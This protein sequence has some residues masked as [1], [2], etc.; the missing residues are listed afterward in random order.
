M[1][2]IMSAADYGS[3]LASRVAPVILVT[4]YLLA[5]SGSVA[6][7][8]AK[9]RCDFDGDGRSDLAI[10]VPG[11]NQGRGAVNGQY[12]TAGFLEVGAYVRRGLNLPG[13][14]AAH[15]RVGSSLA[16]GN[17]NGDAYADLA[18]S[19]PGE[20]TARGAVLVVYGSAQGLTNLFNTYLTQDTILGAGA[21]ED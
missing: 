5:E 1:E 15:Q 8:A 3:V 10:G 17:F 21:A 16:C 11:D 20:T 9:L 18:V 4:A 2:V 19:A 14:A 7:A 12:S 6:T 13:S